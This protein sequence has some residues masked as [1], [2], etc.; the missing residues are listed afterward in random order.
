MIIG[1]SELELT[2]YMA[3][4]DFSAF[5]RTADDLLADIKGVFSG[6]IADEQCGTLGWPKARDLLVFR[7]GEITLW[8]GSNGSRKSMLTGQ[9]MLDLAQ[10]GYKSMTISLEMSARRTLERM[11]RQASTARRPTPADCDLAAAVMRERVWIFDH[12]GSM[13]LDRL[14]AVLRWGKKTLKVEH[15]LIDSMTKIVNGD[16]DYNAQK[17]F[18]TQMTELAKETGLHLHIVAHTRKPAESVEKMPTKWDIKGTS[19]VSGVVS[20]NG[21]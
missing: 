15:V 17:Q 10:Q 16:D 7:P 21:K 20:E 6:E 13:G 5:V 19:S 9:V 14:C 4:P 12:V 18:V 2:D 1:A 11:F 8:A 3:E